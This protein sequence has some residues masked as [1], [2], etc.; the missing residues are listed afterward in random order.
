MSF[1]KIKDELKEIKG[2]SIKI[3][4]DSKNGFSYS[5]WCPDK[6]LYKKQLYRE[7]LKLNEQCKDV[8]ISKK[9]CEGSISKYS[10]TTSNRCT[11]GI[12]TFIC[13][14]NKSFLTELIIGYEKYTK[15]YIAK[16]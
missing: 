14:N 5:L 11:Y 15:T 10:T 8:T 2:C 9:E 13:D 7:M 12:K 1:E 16:N 4:E 6:M 3:L